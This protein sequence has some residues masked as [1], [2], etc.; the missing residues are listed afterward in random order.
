MGI[1]KKKH[2][3]DPVDFLVLRNELVELKER[4]DAS[5]QSKASL[6]DRLSSL[7]ATTMVL[8]STSTSDTAEIVEQIEILQSRVLAST[9][10]GSNVDSLHQRLADVEQ[11]QGGGGTNADLTPQVRELAA[12]L[13]QVAEMTAEMIAE[14]AARPPFP[15]APSG[16][17]APPSPPAA[18]LTPQLAQL[19]A[20]IDHVTELA[21]AP[22]APDEQLTARLD[23]L[24][25]SAESIDLMSRQIGQLNAR[26]SAQAEFAE[27][28]KALSDRIGLLQQRSVDSDRIHA[29]LDELASTAPLAD[30]LADRVAALT[31][32]LSVGE[33][34]TRLARDQAAELELKLAEMTAASSVQVEQRLVELDRRVH[35]DFAT[36]LAEVQERIAAGE[37]QAREYGA[38]LEAQ[39]VEDTPARLAQL[40]AS[41]DEQRALGEQIAGRVQSHA[42]LDER[43]AQ[44]EAAATA[45]DEIGGRIDELQRRIDSPHHLDEQVAALQSR[46]DQVHAAQADQSDIDELRSQAT[47]ATAELAQRLGEIA[48]RVSLTAEE[49]RVARDRS[50]LIEQ[51]LANDTTSARFDEEFSQMKAQLE[52]QSGLVD[53]VQ[54]FDTRLSELRTRSS[55]VSALDQRVEQLA[56]S[57]PSGDEVQRRIDEIV[58]RVTVSEQDARTAC[59]QA[60]VLE[61]RIAAD[62]ATIQA[63]SSSTEQIARRLDELM[64]KVEA[65]SSWQDQLASLDARVGELGE[66]GADSSLVD[67]LHER[68]EQLA[69]SVPD[70]D[71]IHAQ[72][73]ELAHR[74]ANNEVDARSAREQATALDDR[75][76][77]VSTQLANQ[78]AELGSELD[79]LATRE[80]VRPASLDDATVQ[81]MK[82]GQ[83]RLAAEQARYEIT[84]REDLATLAEQVRQLRGRS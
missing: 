50:A 44:L 16:S 33:D 2:A 66:R 69:A 3:I 43:I 17:S 71:G 57:I 25:R 28:L 8:S 54:A 59:E 74:V 36:R 4:L 7:A 39:T 81:S 13:D 31:A 12:R 79:T 42:H 18:D 20:R 70:T 37:Q 29:R 60:A 82:T 77:N 84:F 76:D 11:H 21:M 52:R 24:T 53:R 38:T 68:L 48:E 73:T 75:I 30:E 19:T 10:V 41:I 63:A 65:Q 26:V 23:G 83:V 6:E 64:N 46:L 45:A 61:Q 78:L 15:P 14:L 80:V 67:G 9:A 1:F 32:R 58:A 22:V 34:E 51:R 27:Q 72:I 56:S 40:S 35:D 47:A 62:A 49:A 5:E 55:D